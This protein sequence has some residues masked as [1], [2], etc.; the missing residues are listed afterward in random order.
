[1]AL[2]GRRED[3]LGRVVVAIAVVASLVGGLCAVT[4]LARVGSRGL[5]ALVFPPDPTHPAPV[6]DGICERDFEYPGSWR[7]PI[8]YSPRLS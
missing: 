8:L 4:G 5:T 7:L 6:V 2:K 3:R 1:M